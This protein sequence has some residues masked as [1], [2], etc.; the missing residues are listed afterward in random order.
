M[1][2][3]SSAT[4]NTR[5]FIV[6]KGN[7]GAQAVPPIQIISDAVT[8]RNR[9]TCLARVV[10][11]DGVVDQASFEVL[12]QGEATVRVIGLP[13]YYEYRATLECREGTYNIEGGSQPGVI[14][15][16]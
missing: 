3:S 9:T 6:R 8:F 7:G 10:F 14:I 12:A 2:E 16:R 1:A 4:S 11:P 15:D 13:G 5:I